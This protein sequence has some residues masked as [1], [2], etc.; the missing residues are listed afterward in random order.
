M[1]R[2][3]KSQWPVVLGLF[4]SLA[5]VSLAVS[6]DD[7]GHGKKGGGGRGGGGHGWHG[8][9]NFSQNFFGLGPEGF[10]YG[11]RNENFGLLIGPLGGG[12]AEPYYAAPVY[13]P[14]VV[15]PP[16]VYAD[17]GYSVASGPVGNSP[18]GAAANGAIDSPAP[19][20]ANWLYSNPGSEAETF[21]R[22][23]VEAF[24]DGDYGKASKLADHA[25]VEDTE[26]GQLRVYASQCLLANAEFA[27]SAAALS[28]GLALIEPSQWGEEVKNFRNVY[29][30]NDYVT[31]IKQ[32]EKMAAD[33]PR[34][35]AAHAL[36]A[37][38]FH[39]LG[40]PAAA[41][42]HWNAARESSPQDRLVGQLAD[43]IQ[44]QVPSEEL[45]QPKSVL[46]PGG[47]RQVAHI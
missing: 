21:Y 25:I 26:S 31:H 29:Q 35:P 19:A 14:V 43:L 27:A 2:T 36:L 37:Y 1:S 40:H 18:P 3:W 4:L 28:D 24:R 6:D 23:S 20:S 7:R 17:P 15:N 5:V 46:Q 44:S 13:D 33:H 30:R 34:D 16:V 10:T 9:D 41:Q 47:V 8:D 12:V 42:R 11:Y 32:L 38:H 45:P 39:Y 22:Q